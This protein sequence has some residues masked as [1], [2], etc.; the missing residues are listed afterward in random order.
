MFFRK[1]LLGLYSKNEIFEN[2]SRSVEISTLLAE[3]GVDNCNISRQNIKLNNSIAVYSPR[4]LT[5]K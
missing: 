5:A 1:F 3:F 2:L 4:F